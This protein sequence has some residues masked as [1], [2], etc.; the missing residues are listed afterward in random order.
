M[1]GFEVTF[2]PDSKDITGWPEVTQLFG[3]KD[4]DDTVE[5][6]EFNEFN[7]GGVTNEIKHIEY[8]IDK[9]NSPEPSMHSDFEGFRFTLFSGEQIT[10]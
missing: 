8:C 6:V 2:S 5:S 1:S 7:I 10:L 3:N 4:L 9:T